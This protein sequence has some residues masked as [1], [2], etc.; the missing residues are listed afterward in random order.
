MNRSVVKSDRKELIHHVSGARPALYGLVLQ[1]PS[2]ESWHSDRQPSA[3]VPSGMLRFLAQAS[4]LTYLCLVRR[5]A[6]Q[7]QRESLSLA[8]RDR[9][10]RLR[11]FLFRY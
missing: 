9:F 7:R 10:E 3:T 4:S 6:S 11:Q 8:S 2:S 1:G 5:D